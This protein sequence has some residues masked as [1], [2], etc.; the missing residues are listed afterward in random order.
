MILKKVKKAAEFY[1]GEEVSEVVITVPANFN[2]IERKRTKEAASLAGLKVERIINILELFNGVL[3]VMASRGDSL[4]GKDIDNEIMNYILKRFYEINKI[5]LDIKD[6]RILSALKNASEEC[7][8]NLSYQ[9]SWDIIIPY[10]TKN[11]D[12]NPVDL[13]INITQEDL[14]G[15]ISG[16]V[17][18]TEDIIDETV[19]IGAAL[20]CAIK[21]SA[22]EKERSIIVIDACSHTL[23]VEVFG[24][25]FDTI[26]ERDSKLPIKVTKKY[27]TVEDDQEE[28]EINIY[29]G[30]EYIA[31]KM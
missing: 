27:R 10:I 23:G 25:V 22:I 14:K 20:G 3:D 30:E 12:N 24:G 7:K 2:D 5:T 21:N 26:I 15:L 8:K 18:K 16:I 29:E 11:E 9:S 4:G 19:A 6:L 28:A 17:R 1:L 31:K 13:N